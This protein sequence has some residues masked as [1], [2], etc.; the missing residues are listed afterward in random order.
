MTQTLFQAHQP[1]SPSLVPVFSA[2]PAVRVGSARPE[3][4]ALPAVL[5]SQCGKRGFRWRH[6]GRRHQKGLPDP[7]Q[8]ADH[9][10]RP[11]RREP[12]H[13]GIA[14]PV[15]PRAGRCRS[16][17]RR[18]PAWQEFHPGLPQRQVPFR[19]RCLCQAPQKLQ[20]R[21]S[22]VSPVRE[23]LPPLSPNRPAGSVHGW[24]LWFPPP[25]E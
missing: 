5:C 18:V 6:S 4:A 11:Y 17:Q 2:D 12:G 3:A 14:G 13:I 20:P 19:R 7:P 10:G 24:P 22:K 23:H 1:P 15:D 9:L 8:R 25:A 16:G 21:L